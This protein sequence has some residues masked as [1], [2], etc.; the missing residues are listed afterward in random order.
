MATILEDSKFDPQRDLK[1]VGSNPVKHDGL[2]KVTGRAKFGADFFL[3]GMLFG[4]TLRSPHPHAIIKSID[5]SEAEALPGVKAVVTRDDFPDIDP[6][7]V[8]GDMTR[9]AMA[10]EKAL[11]DGHPVAAVAAT[12]EAIAKRA[13]KLIKVDYEVL[14]HVIDPVDAMKPDAPILH[15]H[16]RTKGL[17]E[18]SD[19]PTNVTERMVSKMGDVERGFAEAD[20]IVEREFDSKP[21]HQGYIE[22]Q[23][24]VAEYSEDGQ[25]ELW[26]STQAPFVY[27]DRLSAIL[28]VDAAKINVQQSELGGGFGGKTGFYPEP[29]AILLSKKASRPVKMVLHRSEVFRGTGPVSGTNYKIKMGCTKDGRITAA[30]GEL[31]FQT[32]I[33]T[34][35]M[36]FNA[37]NAM[38]TRYDLENVYIES[39]E[40]ISNRPKVNSFRA[41]CVPQIVF[42]VEGVIDELAR[43]IEMDPI[44]MRLKNAATEGY[45]TIYGET[46]GPIGFVE[47]LEAA[48]ATDHYQSPVKEG[49]G[50]GIATGFWFNRGGETSTSMNIAPDGSVTIIT[51]TADVAG[52]RISIAMMAAEELG[53]DVDKVRITMADTNSLGFNRVTAGSRTTYSVGMTVVDNARD[54]ISQFVK[55]A[56]EIWDVPEDAVIYENGECRPASANAG[57]FEPLSIAD[58]AKQTTMSHGAVTASTSM[59]VTGAG[60]GFGLHIVDVKVDEETGR[61]DVTRYTVIEDAGK[62]IHPLQVEGQ[63]QG[64]AVQGIGWALNEE[65]VYGEDGRLQN[66]GFLDYRMPVTSDVPMIDTVIV[67][68][69][70]PRHPFGLR[71]VGEVPVVPTMAAIGNAIGDAIGV[72]PQSLPMS[73]PKLLDLI[74]NRD[75]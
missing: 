39:L 2:D 22:P 20:V 10:R 21:M 63:Y 11:F 28:K 71:G 37:P 13:L 67:E 26:C 8:A 60:P 33:F 44:D 32:G 47:T 5:T 58:I 61:T 46:L 1:T 54:C 74:E 7:S 23:G 48:K 57:E 9:T 55:R 43:K 17:D 6:G 38:F 68:V 15:D 75:G 19:A 34:G 73:P 27:R 62:A 45:T 24:C 59:N 35:S 3:P 53:I 69:P 12:S 40:V 72:R 36:Y 18:P 4:R 31:I 65:Y 42:G 49:E 30:Q 41:P 25:V 56:A 29:I 64:G 51:G 66:A 70:N 50:R 16:I 52:S 14:P